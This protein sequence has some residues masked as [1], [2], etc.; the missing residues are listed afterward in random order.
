[1]D[2]IQG[3]I[4]DNETKRSR[5]EWN[6]KRK[7]IRIIS[8]SSGCY[9]LLLLL[10]GLSTEAV[11]SCAC[12]HMF[13]HYTL[14]V[15]VWFSYMCVRVLVLAKL[16][17]SS[18]NCYYVRLLTTF[19]NHFIPMWLSLM[20]LCSVYSEHNFWE[21]QYKVLNTL[22]ILLAFEYTEVEYWSLMWKYNHT[23]A[24]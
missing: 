21:N 15:D 1:M 14:H 3:W 11:A 22:N 17:A 16:T 2:V 5:T 23:Y 8:V 18:I 13:V 12:I 7:A 20:L 6:G 24:N 10:S 19:N 9:H 4:K